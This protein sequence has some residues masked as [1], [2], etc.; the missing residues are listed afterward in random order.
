MTTG[1]VWTIPILGWLLFTRMVT[2]CGDPEYDH[3]KTG[4]NCVQFLNEKIQAGCYSYSDIQK[5]D[6]LVWFSNTIPKGIF[7]TQSLLYHSKIRYVRFSDPCCIKFTH[8]KHYMA[9]I[10]SCY[11]LRSILRSPISRVDCISSFFVLS[12]SLVCV[13]FSSFILGLFVYI[14]ICVYFFFSVSFSGRWLVMT[15]LITPPIW[16]PCRWQLFCLKL[17]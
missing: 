9:H 13:C 1:H 12:C 2:V 17:K 15:W 16:A 6:L 11:T 8:I 10:N 7:G 4:Q 3:S 14:Y 5:A